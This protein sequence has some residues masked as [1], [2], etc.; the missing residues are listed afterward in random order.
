MVAV[1]LLGLSAGGVVAAAEGDKSAGKRQKAG[2]WSKAGDRHKASDQHK[3]C[4][5]Q[6]VGLRHKAG[7]RRKACER[8]NAG[9]QHLTGDVDTRRAGRRGTRFFHFS[10]EF[11]GVLRGA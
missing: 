8:H 3:A 11:T 7:E 4:E 1:R 6:K 2:E 9:E 10:S 5:R